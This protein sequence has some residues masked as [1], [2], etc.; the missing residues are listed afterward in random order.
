VICGQGCAGV[1]STGV[2]RLFYVTD[3]EEGCNEKEAKFEETNFVKWAV[4]IVRREGGSLAL[5]G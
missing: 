4:K 5:S 1:T 2:A 3:F